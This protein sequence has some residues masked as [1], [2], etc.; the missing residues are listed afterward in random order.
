MSPPVVGQGIERVDAP[1]KVTGKA[2]Y[3]AEIAVA[4]VAHA[5]MVTST[6]ARGKIAEIDTRAAAQV[7]GVLAVLTHL[8]APKLPKT[9]KASPQDRVLQILQDDE[10]HYNDQPIA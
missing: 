5:V 9:K 2:D 6:I 3:A 10:V 7:P 1:L 4:N 8:N